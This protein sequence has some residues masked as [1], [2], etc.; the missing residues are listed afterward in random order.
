MI[1][2]TAFTDFPAGRTLTFKPSHASIAQYGATATVNR[3]T[4][5]E[6]RPFGTRTVWVGLT[7]ANGIVLDW[8]VSWVRRRFVKG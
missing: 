1:L 8:P 4:V 3:V 6:S 5:S 7:T 2:T